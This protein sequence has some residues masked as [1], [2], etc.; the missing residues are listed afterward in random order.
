MYLGLYGELDKARR[1]LAEDS[2]METY[3]EFLDVKTTWSNDEFD[4]DDDD[5]SRHVRKL[6]W[7]ILLLAD[8]DEIEVRSRRNGRI[9]FP[10][11]FCFILNF[12]ETY[13]YIG[14]M[15]DFSMI[16]LYIS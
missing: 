16:K 11:M 10:I 8:N 7:I 2:K 13:L 3:E 1:L 14:S 4:D 5:D 9:N 15:E 12:N 6:P